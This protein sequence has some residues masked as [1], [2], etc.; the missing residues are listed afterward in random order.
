[1]QQVVCSLFTQLT[2]ACLEGLNVLSLLFTCAENA[3]GGF[4]LIAI[5]H[6]LRYQ[7]C[8]N[9][10]NLDCTWIYFALIS[11]ISCKIQVS[12]QGVRVDYHTSVWRNVYNFLQTTS[13]WSVFFI[14]AVCHLLSEPNVVQSINCCIS[15]S[16]E[17]ECDVHVASSLSSHVKDLLVFV[18]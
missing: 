9:K 12:T 17:G 3:F 18:F 15:F 5:L 4:F 13:W 1:M 7:T 11:V 6:C 2:N 16:L 10:P 8:E 14:A